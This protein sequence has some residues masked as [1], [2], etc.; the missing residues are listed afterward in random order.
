MV[1]GESARGP[2]FI[3]RRAVSGIEYSRCVDRGHCPRVSYGQF[4]REPDYK[5]EPAMSITWHAANAYC[6]WREKRLPT[7]EEYEAT[8]QGLTWRGCCARGIVPREWTSEP[9]EKKGHGLQVRRAYGQLK[10][11]SQRR[12]NG[13]DSTTV[14][15][16]RDP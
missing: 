7:L 2:F 13:Y 8:W 9:A 10:Q 6:T 1:R 15:C 3:D 14:R 4:N 12:K 5:D 16:A 11:L